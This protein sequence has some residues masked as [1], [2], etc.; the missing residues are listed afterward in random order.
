MGHWPRGLPCSNEIDGLGWREVIENAALE[1]GSD[2]G[3][4][5]DCVDCGAQDVLDVGTKA[6]EM[7]IQ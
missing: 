4:W 2:E 7:V 5:I 3:S 1:C 6:G